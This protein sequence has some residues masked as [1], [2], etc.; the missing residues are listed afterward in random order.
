MKTTR[1]R[2]GL[3]SSTDST[4]LIDRDNK[5]KAFQDLIGSE[6]VDVAKTD[7]EELTRLLVGLGSLTTENFHQKVSE[8]LLVM[9]ELNASKADMLEALQIHAGLHLDE[10]K[11]VFQDLT[12][13]KLK[14][15]LT[16]GQLATRVIGSPEA[17]YKN[18]DLIRD[19]TVIDKDRSQ[20][21]FT[22]PAH[23][24]MTALDSGVLP[25]HFMDIFN[26]FLRQTGN[27]KRQAAEAYLQKDPKL[28]ELLNK[29]VNSKE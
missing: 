11:E 22:S 24:L 26:P 17:I 7:D 12:K 28:A 23:V 2:E 29:F 15:T 13:T 3:F 20:L 14:E 18:P 6:D 16:L 27:N 19:Y 21:R 1:K 9:K 5:E 8:M 4:E 10:A 25:K